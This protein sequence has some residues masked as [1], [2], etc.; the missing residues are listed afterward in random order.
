MPNLEQNLNIVTSSMRDRLDS[1]VIS[2]SVQ[3]TNNDH[4]I[5]GAQLYKHQTVINWQYTDLRVP[6]H[7]PKTLVSPSDNKLG[8]VLSCEHENCR[9]IR[10]SVM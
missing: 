5:P 2:C 8:V 7:S 1:K 9:S 4:S 3:N 6:T 10:P